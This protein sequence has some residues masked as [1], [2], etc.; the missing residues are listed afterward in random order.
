MKS[1]RVPTD[2]E[3]DMLKEA[4]SFN[5]AEKE[6]WEDFCTRVKAIFGDEDSKAKIDFYLKELNETKGRFGERVA[7][8]RRLEYCLGYAY[9]WLGTYGLEGHAPSERAEMFEKAV[10]WYQAAD[11]AVGFQ[12]D[13]SLRQA[14]SCFGAAKYIE[15]AGLE[16]KIAESFAERGVNLTQS[17]F[18]GAI[19]GTADVTIVPGSA[20]KFLKQRAK[21]AGADEKGSVVTSYFLSKYKG[22]PNTPLN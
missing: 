5:P 18:D 8:E 19:G 1:L 3:M 9:E 4:A 13:Y 12:T 6:Y 2:E 10:M 20:P 7:V 15:E 21:D 14:E 17:Y 16:G 22:D 11:E